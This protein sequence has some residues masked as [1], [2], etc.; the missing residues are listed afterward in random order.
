MF[1]DNLT[2]SRHFECKLGCAKQYFDFGS[3]SVLSS[4]RFASL[5]RQP[6]EHGDVTAPLKKH[7]G[8]SLVYRKSN[9]AADPLCDDALA[10]ILGDIKESE[11]PGAELEGAGEVGEVAD[12]N[13]DP[14]LDTCL[15]LQLPISASTGPVASSCVPGFASGFL[16]N[17]PK[18]PRMVTPC[19]PGP[20][21][22]P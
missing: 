8:P 17:S 19:R 20:V 7:F 13:Q 12:L 22:A 3:S 2:G 1:R 10:L 14:E 16:A 5:T 4:C 9:R 6:W 18:L 15:K 11:V 21:P